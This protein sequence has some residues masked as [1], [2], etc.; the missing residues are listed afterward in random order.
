MKNPVVVISETPEAQQIKTVILERLDSID[1]IK[2]QLKVAKEMLHDAFGNDSQWQDA[3]KSEKGGRKT[4][5]ILEEKIKN[6]NPTA[7]DK[8]VEFRDQLKEI[9]DVLSDYLSEYVRL[10]G[11]TEIERQ[12][13]K[14]YK[15]I[16]KFKISPGQQKM[17]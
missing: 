5:K 9:T 13:G 6:D 7:S 1:K 15:I 3:D 2:E 12:D 14:T 17:F 8:V 4:R 16:R 11:N 10:S